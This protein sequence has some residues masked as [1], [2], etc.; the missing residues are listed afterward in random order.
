M[1]YDL[2]VILEGRSANRGS[3]LDAFCKCKG[4]TG[5]GFK[6]IAAAMY[7]LQD[8]LNTRGEIA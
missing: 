4:G 6:Q 5:G 7:S 8:M 2:Q 3:V 1:F